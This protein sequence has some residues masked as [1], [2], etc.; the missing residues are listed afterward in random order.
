[1]TMT[2]GSITKVINASTHKEKHF[3]CIL[4]YLTINPLIPI[5]K[6]L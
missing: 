1:M 5:T 2:N 3:N 4:K 6:I